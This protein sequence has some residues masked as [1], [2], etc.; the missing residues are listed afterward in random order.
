MTSDEIKQS[1]SMQEVLNMFGLKVN[2]KGFMCC[3]FHNEKTP[4]MK[5]YEKKYHCFGCGEDGDVFSF[6]MKYQGCDFKEA[7]KI[8]GGGYE[9]TDYGR[10]RVK[11]SVAIRKA[12]QNTAADMDEIRTLVAQT[13]NLA[14]E[15]NA[16]LKNAPDKVFSDEHEELITLRNAIVYFWEYYIIDRREVTT[17]AKADII[18]K[19][20]RINELKTLLGAD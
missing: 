12:R 8:L 18:R 1:T 19:C 15:I 5:I 9:N 7:F 16:G 2:R 14:D 13:W 10:E 20:T 3:P 4:S 17:S 11:R 6:V